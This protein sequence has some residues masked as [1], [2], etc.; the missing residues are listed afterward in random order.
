MAAHQWE[1]MELAKM[2]DQIPLLDLVSLLVISDLNLFESL[3]KV[4]PKIAIGK[5]TLIKLQ[6]LLAPMSGSPYRK[7]LEPIQQVLKDQFR[8]IE[9]P[10]AE[11]PTEESFIENHWDSLEIIEIA[12]NER[13]L[14]YSDDIL[15]RIYSQ[16]PGICTLD[17]LHAL[18][19]MGEL[20]ARDVATR[21]AQLCSWRV[22]VAVSQRYQLAVLPETLD[23]AENVSKA[24]DILLA[25][26][27]CNALLGG[28]WNIE[29]PFND[30]QGHAGQ[31]LRDLVDDERNSIKSVAALACFWFAKVRWHKQAPTPSDRIAALLIGQAAFIERPITKN[32]AKRLWDVY[33][34]VIE[35]AYGDFMD[36]GKFSKSLNIMGEI[37]A[38]ADKQ[39]SLQGERSI[40]QRLASGKT[41]GTT[42]YDEFLNPYNAKFS[43]L[44]L[45]DAQRAMSDLTNGN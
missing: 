11:A 7:K 14:I 25:D 38:E 13:Y 21:I 23:N 10:E 9:Q 43:L 28:L 36:E 41:E 20:T 16:Q 6:S 45:Q 19:E 40:G 2:R 22:I 35:Y 37:A 44:A 12:K 4:F 32:I 29:K 31:I 30:L 15:F 1:A 3:F 5:A 34:G 42:E 39:N 27:H 24:A 18:D 17:L 8:N 33:E 26:E